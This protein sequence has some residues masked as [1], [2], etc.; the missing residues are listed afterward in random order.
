MISNKAEAIQVIEILNPMSTDHR[1]ESYLPWTPT[2]VLADYVPD[3]GNEWIVSVSGGIVPAAEWDTYLPKAD[4]TIVICPVMTGG[5]GGAKSILRMVAFIALVVFTA[6]VAMPALAAWGAGAGLF[7]AGSMSAMLASGAIMAVGGMLINAIM[8]VPTASRSSSASDLTESASYGINGAR[9]TAVEGVPVPVV[10]GEHRV[11]G[12]IINLYTTNVEKTQILYMLLN[13][14]EGPIQGIDELRINDQPIDFFEDVEYDI[15]VGEDD[16][17][18]MTWFDDQL[19]PVPDFNPVEIPFATD[20]AAGGVQRLANHTISDKIRIDLVAPSGLFKTNDK[21]EIQATTVP[22]SIKY[23]RVTIAGADIPGEGWQS[24]VASVVIGDTTPNYNYPPYGG[25]DPN[26]GTRRPPIIPKSSQSFLN[27]GEYVVGRTIYSPAGVPKGW[28]QD[29]YVRDYRD[30]AISKSSSPKFTGKSRYPVRITFQTPELTEGYYLCAV[31]RTTAES[32][33]LEIVD[34]VTWESLIQV[35]TDDVGYNHT[36]LVGVKVRLSDQITSVPNITYKHLGVRVPVYNFVLGQWEEGPSGNPAWCALDILTNVRYGGR[37]PLRMI[38]IEGFKRW[39]QFCDAQSPKL[40]FNAVIDQSMSIWDAMKYVCRAGHAQVIRSG[41]KF[42]VVLE[43]PE[44]PVMQFSE[45]NIVKG[46]FN[47]TWLSMSERANAIEVTYFDAEEDYKR[48]TVKTIDPSLT[49][50]AEERVAQITL[51]GVTS[52][53][54]AIK[55]GWLHLNMNNWLTR[56]VSFEAGL[57]AI[58]C[59]VGSVIVVKHVASDS[60]AAGR[61]SD[62]NPLNKVL[63]LDQ[64]V[65]IDGASDT[66]TLYKSVELC[67]QSFGVSNATLRADG[68]LLATLN[69]TFEGAEYTG[70]SKVRDANLIQL[71]TPTG[72]LQA[73]ILSSEP[74]FVGNTTVVIL[75]VRNRDMTGSMPLT[76][77][78]TLTRLWKTDVLRDYAVAPVVD[79]PNQVTLTIP[80]NNPNLLPDFTNPEDV[81]WVLRRES[82]QKKL[83]RVLSI[84]GAADETTRSISAIEYDERVYTAL[85]V[86]PPPVLGDGDLP[87]EQIG[88][89]QNLQGAET[90]EAKGNLAAFKL[91]LKWDKPLTGLYEGAVVYRADSGSDEWETIGSVHGGQLSTV[92]D[93]DEAGRIYH[94]RVQALDVTA[95][96]SIF[97]AAPTLTWTVGQGVTITVIE[98]DAVT[99]TPGAKANHITW[100]PSDRSRVA[101]YELKY[102]TGADEEAIPL[103]HTLGVVIASALP[104]QTVTFTHQNL[105]AAAYRYWVR[106]IPVGANPT[107]FDPDAGWMASNVVRPLNS[108]T[109]ILDYLDD[110]IGQSHLDAFLRTRIDIVNDIEVRIAGIDELLAQLDLINQIPD[111]FAQFNQLVDYETFIRVTSHLT[112]IGMALQNTNVAVLE[113]RQ[114][115]DNGL[116]AAASTT[117]ILAARM[118][119]AEAG[120]IEERQVRAAQDLAAATVSTVLAAR[121]T[122]VETAT[123]VLEQVDQVLATDIAAEVS[124]RRQLSAFLTGEEEG[125]IISGGVIFEEQRVRA[126]A[127]SANASNITII[128]TRLGNEGDIGARIVTAESTLVTQGEEITAGAERI[129]GLEAVVTDEGQV[130]GSRITSIESTQVTLGEE[131][132]AE[133]VRINTINSAISNEGGAVGSRIVSIESTNATQGTDISTAAARIGVVESRI[134]VEGSTNIG[135]RIAQIEQT[136]ATTSAAQANRINSIESFT[137]DPTLPL[138]TR[139]VSAQTTAITADGRSI[140]NASNI[141]FIEGRIGTDGQPGTILG[142]IFRSED[143]LLNETTGVVRQLNIAQ[144]TIGGHT[145]AIEQRMEIDEIRGMWSVR[146]DANGRVGGMALGTEQHPG[147]GNQLIDF[148]IIADRFSISSPDSDI[149]PFI[150]QNG[151]VY[152]RGAFIE[153]LSVGSGSIGNNAITNVVHGVNAVSITLTQESK[154]LIFYRAGGSVYASGVG[155]AGFG[156]LVNVKAILSG[157]ADSTSTQSAKMGTAPGETDVVEIAGEGVTIAALGPGTWTFYLSYQLS[158]FGGAQPILNPIGFLRD[159]VIMEIKK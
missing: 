122:G 142:R 118:E 9:A 126:E 109:D 29:E 14:G 90:L 75:D 158:W 82:E 34:G 50:L 89:V 18:I 112:R 45:A 2:T 61:V 33:A 127:D 6:G 113:T 154:L 111:I 97:S 120:I 63:T 47:V 91:G 5:G 80:S 10:Y 128:E 65:V 78:Q 84:S 125:D 67:R 21:G 108:V 44:E 11:A 83:Y 55:E 123:A 38:D 57:E 148:R 143:V 3:D 119:N 121:V 107:T 86:L 96:S 59:T 134:T 35:V 145:T 30:D 114:Q 16:Q 150:V 103:D 98:M 87:A 88:Q 39:A 53:E 43:A 138:S 56:T 13:A 27:F 135:S 32:E 42:S 141:N 124:S 115:L 31:S 24:D 68:T 136:E 73:T 70:G 69:A 132:E 77:N 106:V 85:G 1:E 71:P 51:I 146:L 25:V 52:R 95:K 8:P 99:A 139:I 133:A 79:N 64:D 60:E 131:I 12:N 101:Y 20:A 147:N 105:A 26:D 94:I 144:L 151:N 104:A 153:N 28:V 58:A 46:T 37:V 36:A 110:L 40:R 4:D 76:G 17:E 117:L 137:M 62:Y 130:I 72:L 102:Q 156:G 41:I 157:N 22:L 100:S 149:S 129:S 19:I 155:G 7:V 159:I 54:Q 74:G 15:R 152:M 23:K 81:H 49:D 140:A 48:K 116:E 93:A 66:L 92:I